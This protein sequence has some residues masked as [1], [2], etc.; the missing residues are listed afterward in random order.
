MHC[1]VLDLTMYL[2][3]VG[4][5]PL[6]GGM[7]WRDVLGWTMNNPDDSFKTNLSLVD[8]EGLCNI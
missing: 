8:E 6:R 5:T 3:T 1:V 2:Y 7:F 4:R